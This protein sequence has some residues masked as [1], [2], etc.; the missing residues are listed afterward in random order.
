M[1]SYTDAISPVTQGILVELAVTYLIL[2][3]AAQITDLFNHPIR[4]V[5]A[6]CVA[7]SVVYHHIDK[8]PIGNEAITQ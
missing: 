2:A 3:I 4:V 7:F 1:S 5:V 8:L 6:V